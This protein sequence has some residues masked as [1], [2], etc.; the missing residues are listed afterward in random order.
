[1][2][3][4]TGKSTSFL[5]EKYAIRQIDI[6][7]GFARFGVHYLTGSGA[8][9]FGAMPG[10]SEHIE[11]LMLNRIGL[12]P[13]QALAAAINNFSIFNGWKDIGLIE[14]G[15]NADLLVLSANPL[16]NLENL[17]NIEMLW[18]GGELIDRNTLLK[19]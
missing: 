11:I 1:M 10:I 9:A 3:T 16:D 4:A 6:E 13:R 8:D 12:S 18:L 15:R 14:D 7:K 5:T 17:K 19:K 2:D